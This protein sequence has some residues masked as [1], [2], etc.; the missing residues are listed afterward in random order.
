[1][2]DACGQS[3][4]D[5]HESVDLVMVSQRKVTGGLRHEFA[6]LIFVQEQAL[7][8]TSSCDAQGERISTNFPFSLCVRAD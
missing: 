7:R 2:N 5:G 4:H 3:M 1:M 8:Q 6:L